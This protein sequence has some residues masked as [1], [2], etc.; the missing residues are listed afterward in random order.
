VALEI[1]SYRSV[2][3]LE[4]RIYRI[5]RVRLNPSGVPVRGMLYFLAAL[6]ATL[7]AVRLPLVGAA[8]DVLPWYLRHLALPAVAAALMGVIRIDGR[9]FH[10][11]A[12]ALLRY[13]ITPRLRMRDQRCS[14]PGYRWWP[15]EMVLLPDGSDHRMRRLRYVG[16]GAVLTRPSHELIEGSGS[17]LA[18]ALRRDHLTI[19]ELAGCRPPASAKVVVLRAG[20]RLSTRGSGARPRARE[21]RGR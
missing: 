1:R 11:A 6:L 20:T 18:R 2:F 5:D 9:P 7:L 16:P 10:L 12:G 17:T 3:D 19:A 13:G 14:R 21:P 15:G 8:M 4:R